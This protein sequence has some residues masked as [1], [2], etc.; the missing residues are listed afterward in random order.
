M[1]TDS[2]KDYLSTCKKNIDKDKQI[3]LSSK[4]VDIVAKS[5]FRSVDKVRVLVF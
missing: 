5:V 4:E 3:N 2:Y 1:N